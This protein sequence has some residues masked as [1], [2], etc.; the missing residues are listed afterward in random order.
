MARGRK[1]D[2]ID[3]FRSTKKLIIQTGYEGFTIGQ[4]AKELNVTR[5][6]I[7]K[8]Y[9]NK[10][11]LLL[12]FMLD[13]ITN[14]LTS[15]S[16]IPK[17]L[18]FLEKLD[19]LLEKIFMYKDL[20][21]ILGIGIPTKNI[22]LLEA[23]KEKLSHMHHELYKPLIH[24]VQQGKEE[25]FIDMDMPNEM[26]LGFIFQSISIPNHSGMDAEQVLIYT[27]KL[28]LDGIIKRK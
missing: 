20:H 25:G 8:Y 27:K 7:Y 26:L 22:P 21:L 17:E 5:A 24:I 10:D 9:Q 28:I 14:T 16:S 18:P 15:F 1:F 13:E 6:A 2:T 19:L 11:E 4:L 3:L 23:K 12:D